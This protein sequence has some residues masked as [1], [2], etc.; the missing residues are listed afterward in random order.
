M[1]GENVGQKPMRSGKPNHPGSTKLQDLG[2]DVD[3]VTAKAFPLPAR[4][5]AGQGDLGNPLAEIPSQPGDL[6]PCRVAP[7]LRHRHA[8][9]SDPL[10]KLLNHVFLIAPLI[11]N[12]DD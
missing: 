8:P 4:H 10:T 11:G 1:S 9:T 5:L 7:K 12:I 6:E 3:K 2:C